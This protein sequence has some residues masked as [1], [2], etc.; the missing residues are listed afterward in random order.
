M[1]KLR[2]A[3]SVGTLGRVSF[4]S[5]KERM[6]KNAKEAREAAQRA[7][8]LQAQHVAIANEQLSVEQER[9]ELERRRAVAAPPAA[10]P[11]RSA[12]AALPPPPI[13]DPAALVRHLNELAVMRDTGLLT[14]EEF[15]ALK[16]WI[17]QL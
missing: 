15:T 3:A 12:S 6:P 11:T 10:A 9:L 7:A 4:R 2:K 14:Q 16:R 5:N 13:N 17:V 8:E 1:G